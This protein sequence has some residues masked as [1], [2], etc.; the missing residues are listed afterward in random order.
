MCHTQPVPTYSLT[1]KLLIFVVLGLVF[2]SS[3]AQQVAA[4]Q[5]DALGIGL[6]IGSPAGFSFK[7]W[8]AHTR[9]IDGGAAWAIGK[10]PGVH[11]HADYLYH[12]S[13]LEG[14]QENRSYAYYGLGARLKLE[15]EDARL[16]VRIVT[17]VT[18]LFPDAP[19]DAFFDVVPVF[20]VVPETRL[21]LNISI[22]VRFYLS[23][24]NDERK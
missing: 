13:D 15:E 22:G 14:L 6:M 12:R 5:R 16:G 17:G 2:A 21:V 9:A 4:Q 18:Y 10:N 20:D 8:T 7:K 23:P 1:L 3:T 19:L 11:L 24:L